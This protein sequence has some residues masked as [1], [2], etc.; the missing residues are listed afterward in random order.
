MATKTIT[1]SITL[2]PD[3]VR[4]ILIA[5]LKDQFDLDSALQVEFKLVTVPSSD[6]FDRGPSEKAFGSAIIS[7][8]KQINVGVPVGYEKLR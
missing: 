1:H 3:D 6:Y 5:A 4:D 2:T 8:T 7:G